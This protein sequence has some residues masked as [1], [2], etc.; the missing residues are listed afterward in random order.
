[1]STRGS[2]NRDSL[3]SQRTNRA[4]IFKNGQQNPIHPVSPNR[5]TRLAEKEEMQSLNDRLC[6]YIETVRS[7]Q[8][9]NQRLKNEMSSYSEV[10]TRDVSEIKVMYQRE[11]EDAK[12]LIDE[13]AKEKAKFEI[14][15][16]K[17]KANAVDAQEKANRFEREAKDSKI[18]HHQIEA[19]LAEYKTR[20]ESMRTD[21]ARKT[22]SLNTLQPHCT[23]L[24]KHLEKLR[25]Q[26]E[27]E[28]L[29]RVDLEN[30][31]ST[32][33]EDLNFKSQIY[34]KETDQL[35]SSKR[36]EI[37]QVD[38]RLRDEYDSKLMRELNNI[39]SEAEGKIKEM[40]D[41]VEKRYRNKHQ[42]SETT[43]KRSEHII[44][45]LRDELSSAG[46]KC[47]DYETDIDALRKK[48]TTYEQRIKEGE[49]KLKKQQVK[50]DK[51][52]H[53]RDAEIEK[54][55]SELNS[56]L[57]DYQ[58]LYD[59]KIAL[60]MEIEA[61]RKILEAEETR[62][63][64]TVNTSK[65]HGSYIND[66]QHGSGS[67]KSKKRK[68]DGEE[69]SNNYTEQV[70]SSSFTSVQQWKQSDESSVGLIISEFEA[71]TKSLR[72]SNSTEQD[73][74]VGGFVLK[75]IVD[76]DEVDYKFS[77]TRAVKAG[78]SLT[79]W[80]STSSDLKK[81]DDL[82]LG[83]SKQWLSGDNIVI[84]LNDKEGNELSRRE[85]QKTKEEKQTFLAPDVIKTSTKSTFGKM[86]TWKR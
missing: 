34:E 28:T 16:N 58:E 51:D 54:R 31:N 21:L 43:A 3:S 27:D 7:L 18:A 71:D 86:F 76:G 14:D 50:H 1:M 4:D 15:V 32:L 66:S 6:V 30:K 20:C 56:L 81:A 29:L 9:E 72:L 48:V 45:A 77:K 36:S 67:K 46:T 19:E 52:V 44:E 40:K 22:G 26:L 41:E 10:S 59:I 5:M 57:V 64:I 24:E 13:L 55:R 47:R 78:E 82:V 65:L 42:D 60:D 73:I 2:Q 79:I 85:C 8:T 62:L 61:Y 23:E 80:N 68:V 75:Q 49:D 11:L 63:N 70:A 33:K 25:K 84:L 69:A 83:G 74:P 39:R 38:N 37:E 17:Y 12:N 35:R 53:E